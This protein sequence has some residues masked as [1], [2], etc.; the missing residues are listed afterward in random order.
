L[1]LPRRLL[2]F[3]IFT[4]YSNV[5]EHWFLKISG[6]EL[7][8]DTF[9]LEIKV[10]DTGIG[11]RAE[12]MDKLFQSFQR[13]D[14]EKTRNIEGTGLGIAIVQKLLNMMKSKLEVVSEYGNGS[15]FSFKLVQKI[16]DLSDTYSRAKINFVVNRSGNFKQTGKSIRNRR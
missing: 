7:D 16:I 5:C 9:E 6:K 15:E 13:L 4:L 2:K 12:D 8:S 11:I 1:I 3:P 10:K 14:D